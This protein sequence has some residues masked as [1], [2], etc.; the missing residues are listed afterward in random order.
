TLVGGWHENDTGRVLRIAPSPTCPNVTT[1]MG[2][3]P[4]KTGVSSYE[5]ENYGHHRSL[6]FPAC[7]IVI[8]DFELEETWH[9]RSR[10][11]P[12]S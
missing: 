3:V 2:S 5:K 11:H 9:A 12:I 10:N 6:Y 8:S 4:S 7:A 1:G